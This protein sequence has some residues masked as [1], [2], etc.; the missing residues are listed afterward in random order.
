LKRNQDIVPGIVAI[1]KGAVGGQATTKALVQ[2]APTNDLVNSI[3]KLIRNS[4]KLP[5][6]TKATVVERLSQENQTNELVQ[7]ILQSFKNALPPPTLVSPGSAT[8]EKPKP[9]DSIGGAYYGG[10]RIGW[11]FDTPSGPGFKLKGTK[12]AVIEHKGWRLKGPRNT[13]AYNLY[14]T[15]T[16]R[17]PRTNVPLNQGT[18]RAPWSWPGFSLKKPNG[19]QVNQRPANQRPANQRPANSTNQKP[20]RAPWT[21]PSI[22]S[23]KNKMPMYGPEMKP[24]FLPPVQTG[25]NSNG[26]P[27]YGPPPPGYV[28]T[29]RNNKTGY[30]KNMN[31]KPLNANAKPLN[32]NAKPLNGKPLNANAKPPP[33]LRNYSNMGL[34]QLLNA[35]SRYPENAA[36]ITALIKE[37]FKRALYEL[38]YESGSKRARK[39]GELLRLLPR[40]F[41]GRRNA[42]SLVI[43]NVRNTRNNR[44]LSNLASNLGRV[45]NEN[46]ARAFAEQKKRLKRKTDGGGNNINEIRR[47][48][49]ILGGGSG[50]GYGGGSGGGYG[51]GSGGG[52]GGGSG[53]GY[54]GGSGGNSNLN[55][56]RRRR[57][58]LSRGSGG[59]AG[60]GG[61]GYGG[62]GNGGGYG[63]GYGNGSLPPPPPLPP[64]QQTAINN[65]GGIPRALNTVAAVPGGAP[66]VAK[67]AEALNETGGNVVQAI[68]V[69]GA[70][71][72]AINAVQKL[73][74]KNNAVNVLAGLNT[75]AQ[76]PATRAMKRGPRKTS[77]KFRPRLAE[78]NKVIN[79][80]KKKKLI[81]IIAHNV[82]KTHEIHPNDEKLK[83]YYRKVIKANILRTPFSNIVRKA[84]KK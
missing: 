43:D 28:L 81:S 84:A 17:V 1:I 66:A 26:R 64:T 5:N 49:T 31:A 16:P 24:N 12:D 21:F 20:P 57:A 83:K 42:T 13:N 46:I 60:N 6:T 55:E 74:G 78:L 79:S 10:K 48:R 73:G 61:G 70:S 3:T 9:A 68:N 39:I 56:I 63:G 8:A 82:T 45:P 34:K 62:A 65:A 22:F 72:A 40:T 14:Y 37:L 18:P 19:Q 51:G 33:T 76:K 23:R 36:K 67:A 53:G 38:E 27:N 25:V 58:F 50:G 80:V 7:K 30:Y 29:T 44:E 77:K 52:Y 69:K 2:N 11:V 54:G 4:V 59:G 32:A 71:P 15:K 75:M 41:N 47:R 35:R